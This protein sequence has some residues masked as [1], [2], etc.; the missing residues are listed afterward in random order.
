MRSHSP[1]GDQARGQGLAA[2][3][4]AGLTVGCLS[5][6]AQIS[7][8]AL[9]FSGP[10]GR[11]L[12]SG[13]AHTLLGGVVIGAVMAWR[14]SFPGTVGRPHELPVVVLALLA[15]QLAQRLPAAAPGSDVLAT[16]TMLVMASTALFGLM[17]LLLGRLGAGNLFRYLP[18]PVLGGFV[19]GSGALL[20]KGGLTVM[21]GVGADQLSWTTLA[22][23]A[24]LDRWLPGLAFALLMT[25]A[26][27]RW[28]SWRTIPAFLIGGIAAFHLL[29]AVSGGSLNG[30]MAGGLLPSLPEGMAD[31]SLI[32]SALGGPVAWAELVGILPNMLAVAFLAS[33]GTLLNASAIEVTV[34]RELDLNRDLTAVGVANLLAALVGSPAGFHSLSATALPQQMGAGGRAVGLIASLVCLAAWL[35]GPSLLGAIPFA[36]TG[37]L[38]V[39]LGLALLTDWLLDR[40]RC[41]SPLENAVLLAIL[42]V[43]MLSGWVAALMAG[44]VLALLLFVIDY[45][46]ISAV[47]SLMTGRT[48]RSHVDRSPA[49]SLLLDRYGDAIL[50]MCLQGH[51]F[52]G[53]AHILR[54]TIMGR[55]EV[56]SRS[57]PHWI[58]LD[59]RLTSGLDASAVHTFQRLAQICES[60]GIEL[61]FSGLSA[62]TRRLL[63]RSGILR[64]DRV[65][66]DWFT[67]L[68]H[69]LEFC[70]NELLS[71]HPLQESLEP[72]A[73]IE[74][75]DLS[76]EAEQR[77]LAELIK[78]FEPVC[79]PAGSVII[80]QDA[81]PSDLI[82]LLS[83][84][85]VVERRESPEAAPLRLRTMDPG[86]CIGEI[87]FYLGTPTSASVICEV[88][89]R[90]LRLSQR[91]LV[92]LE[93][94]DP[95]AALLLHR[96]VARKLAQR[97]LATNRL[98]TALA[99]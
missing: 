31:R 3:I 68:D 63:L 39:F 5:A 12:G 79:F 25:V 98:A 88:E 48:R 76:G 46:R 13:V 93:Q 58:L 66:H 17:A 92:A 19:A 49:R 89:V 21:L 87:G 77:A 44:L 94:E 70:E 71:L 33:L 85:V 18:F 29:L 84:R 78:Q 35:G 40:S 16:V 14:G 23:P 15:A 80:H 4:A 47:R 54:R 67:D 95:R 1:H 73:V 56:P 83:G 26:A 62:A 72:M 6:L 41:L 22:D 97:L 51:L 61:V 65:G 81:P 50:V 38:L 24:L 20:V 8:G 36:V 34:R 99:G 59:L 10:L 91:R 86:T 52:F 7:F 2:T 9:L 96:L 28:P 45:S 74:A 37:G 11:A 90:A 57:R 55:L 32:P 43:T 53:T 30:A 60:A 69:G 64:G 82:L 75:G 42:L 27:R